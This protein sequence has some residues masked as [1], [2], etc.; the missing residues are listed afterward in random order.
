MTTEQVLEIID[1][2][3]NAGCLSLTIT[4]GDPMMR[5]DFPEIYR[6]A[7]EKGLLITV[8]CDGVLVTEK[9]VD[10]FREFPPRAVEISLYGAT[11]H[12]YETITR[13][14]GSFSR[15]LRGIHRLLDAG[16]E[17]RLKTVLMNLNVHECDQMRE[18][19]ESLGLPFRV[20]A[21]IFPC[22]HSGDESPVALRV[23]PEQAV[24]EELAAPGATTTW[25]EFLEKPAVIPPPDK[26]Y[27]CGAGITGFFID[28]YGFLSPCLMTTRYRYN[29]LGAD[30]QSLWNEE[31][32][33][34][35]QQ[36]ARKE[37]ECT[38][39]E[40]QRVCSTCPGLNDQETGAEDVKSDYVCTMAKARWQALQP[41]RESGRAHDVEKGT[42]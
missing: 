18:M 19:T 35:H 42:A 39:C 16:I 17:L 3:T 13:V 1:Q 25:I 40:L 30:F 21:A 20:D 10:L 29:L 4:G 32:Q 9:I 5:A 31:M 41:I 2:I 8:L 23:P 36:T 11:A 26:L 6:Y 38:G 28:P 24:R 15:C 22:L 27:I 33:E 14:P 37:Y 12:T 34:L 7:R